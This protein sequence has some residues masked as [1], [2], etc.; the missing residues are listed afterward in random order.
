MVLKTISLFG[1]EYSYTIILTGLV[2]SIL[3]GLVIIGGIKRIA[4]FSQVVI[5]AMAI[6]YFVICLLI[7][8]L[9]AE[10]IPTAINKILENAFDTKAVA[11]GTVGAMFI[12]MQKGI[13]R[14]IFSNEA[15][16]GSAPIAAA[17]AKT[18]EPVRQGLV[19][20][21]GTFIDTII[22][23]SMTGL[24]I[25]V[26]GADTYGLEGV[27]ITTKAFQLGLPFNEQVS[28]FILMICLVFFAFTTIIGWNYYSEKSL[29]YLTKGKNNII[30]VF[31]FLYIF[32][33]LIGPFITVSAVWTIADIFNSL[34]AFPNMI[35]IIC[36]S[37]VVIKETKKYFR[38]QKKI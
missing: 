14:G 23:C 31:R 15:G 7:L 21:L 38:K 34:M 8:I 13:A 3:A 19:Y 11:G 12:A 36:L 25:L 35:A 24:S 6:T 33:V 30:R 20:M 4:N 26:T 37:G 17:A 27:N 28:S 10:N 16:L 29:E 2:V 32:A 9:N 1:S 22:I 5:P 18:K